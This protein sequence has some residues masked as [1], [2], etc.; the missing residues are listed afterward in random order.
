MHRGWK[1][2]FNSFSKKFLSKSAYKD[3]NSQ[4]TQILCLN[5]ISG[6][7]SVKKGQKLLKKPQIG[8]TPGFMIKILAWLI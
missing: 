3:K 5:D 1:G 4:R 7:K 8:L 2:I 6:S